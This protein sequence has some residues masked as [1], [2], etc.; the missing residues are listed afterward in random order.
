MQHARPLKAAIYARVS[1]DEQTRGNYPSCDS[2]I[3]ELARHCKERGFEMV[4]PIKDEGYSAGSLK[5][6]GLTR[7]RALVSNGEIQV[8]RCTWY[9]RLSRARDFYMI[10]AE[11]Q[12]HN[13]NFGTLHDSAD[14]N[15]AAG[16]FM[17]S[18]VI[19]AKTYE[20]EQTAEKVSL[21]MTM[22]AEKG[23]YS[24][25]KTPFAFLKD[26]STHILLPN[27]E[28]V[29]ILRQIF[30]IYVRTQSD[31]A[32]RDWLRNQGIAS[33]KGNGEWSAGSI[34]D[35]LS[36]PRYVALIEINKKRKRAT[37]LAEKDSYRLVPAPYEPLV[38]EDLFN[39]AQSIRKDKAKKFPGQSRRFQKDA[40]VS[41]KTPALPIGHARTFSQS[42]SGYEFELQ[43]II[44]CA[45]CGH[46]MS[47][48][49]V[50]KVPNEKEKRRTHSFVNY[51]ECSAAR[52]YP[53]IAKHS[54]RILARKA[55]AWVREQ[56]SVLALDRLGVD[57]AVAAAN[58]R[59][60]EQRQ[61]TREQHLRVTE[62]LHAN[63]TQIDD[64]TSTLASGAFDGALLRLLSERAAKLEI[65][66]NT[67]MIEKRQL[68]DQL[69]LAEVKFDTDAFMLALEYCGKLFEAENQDELR[70]FLRIL[71]KKIVWDR[72]GNHSILFSAFTR[73]SSKQAPQSKK[74]SLVASED[75]FDTGM[76]TAWPQGRNVE[77]VL[78][79]FVFGVEILE[80]EKTLLC[81][82][83]NLHPV[84]VTPPS[85]ASVGQK[86]ET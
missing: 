38:P 2:Q 17:E 46:P 18:V 21:K 22:R 24:N 9:D 33:P 37:G 57:Q 79:V 11:F 35:L 15:T 40:G 12:K 4:A 42:K 1:T 80:E 39:L 5:R 36:N 6:P 73:S 30:E 47:P 58:A 71:V 23:M 32:V 20:R 52:K 82:S 77:P 69:A 34:R 66:R 55:E 86:E 3:D 56:I 28:Q 49:Y 7:L 16:R 67:L 31:F 74:S 48:Y 65:E 54:N 51:Y 83:V 78:L 76:W 29:P 45:C 13:I 10:D 75:W 62:A 63:Q 44:S 70:A 59:S 25:G 27:P 85:T 41:S 81:P 19:A 50:E 43:S 14:R 60:A 84:G 53:N 64:L 68:E 72:N 8:V 26:P 61:P